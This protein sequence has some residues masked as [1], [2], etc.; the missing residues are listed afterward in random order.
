MVALR[1]CIAAAAVAFLAFLPLL[2]LPAPPLPDT[3]PHL[4]WLS[5]PGAAVLLWFFHFT[6][7]PLWIAPAL[8]L[9]L[10]AAAGVLLATLLPQLFTRRATVLAV[11]IYAAHPL[12][13]D[14]LALPPP[15]AALPG[16]VLALS[17]ALAFLHA[18]PR[19]G[20]ALALS[21]LLFEPAAA[22][23]PPVLFLL[24][25]RTAG[26]RRLIWLGAAGAAAWLAALRPVWPQLATEWSSFGIYALRS[27]FLALFPLVLTPSPDLHGSPLESALAAFAVAAASWAAWTAGR[28]HALGAWLL[29]AVG[30][31]A[32]V[33]FTPAADGARGLALPLVALSAFAA[34]LLEQAD[35][36]LS[37]VYIAALALLSFN[38]ARLWRDPAALWMEAVRL[39]P[40]L[41]APVLALAPHLPPTQALELIADARRHAPSDPRLG[42]AFGNALLRAQRPREAL[43][44]F[45]L[46]LDLDPRSHA[47]WT[48]RAAAWLALES[49]YAARADLL[50]A[51]ALEPCSLNARLALSRLGDP[52]P[53]DPGCPWT[54]AQ[55]RALAAATSRR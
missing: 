30:L 49:P 45:D 18:R 55:R 9:A 48:G 1:L 47:A 10:H 14:S 7:P 28:R 26:S 51:L 43:S 24:A 20:T 38:Y 21:A 35:M 17:A 6:A 25:G 44:E 46:A 39:A 42:T 8:A 4:P 23:I 53:R 52:P 19:T 22:A 29:S 13:T 54:H 2:G 11:L 41:P 27:V 32:A 5:R 16:V 34:L 50:R 15:A 40:R 12:H 37:A 31:L 33:F 36:R 3:P